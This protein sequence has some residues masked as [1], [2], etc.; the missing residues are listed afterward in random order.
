MKSSTYETMKYA[1][2]NSDE[3]QLWAQLNDVRFNGVKTSSNVTSDGSISKGGGLLSTDC[4]ESEDELLSISRDLILSK[5]TVL[6]CAK[7]D[8]HL[9]QL[10]DA[11][12]D[13]VQVGRF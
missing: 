11:L 8:Q 5:E 4:H 3:L 10:V 2:I 13:F 12:G 7:T 6:Q 1:T 9:K